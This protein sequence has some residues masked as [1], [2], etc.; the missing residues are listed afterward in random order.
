MRTCWALIREAS[1]SLHAR[2]ELDHDLMWEDNMRCLISAVVP[3]SLGAPISP[4]T[5]DDVASSIAGLWKI[6][7]F[8]RNEVGMGK[9]TNFYGEHP[10]GYVIYT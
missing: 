5:A 7:S 2:N 1:H 10:S 3:I 4:A 9:A 6:T 8:T